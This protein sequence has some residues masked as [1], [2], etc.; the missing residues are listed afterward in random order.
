LE[1]SSETAILRTVERFGAGYL[2]APEVIE[3]TIG[4]A[5]P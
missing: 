3:R 2:P 5:T 1:T 4:C